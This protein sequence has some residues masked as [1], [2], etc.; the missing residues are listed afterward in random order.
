MS[1]SKVFLKHYLEDVSDVELLKFYRMNSYFR[2]LVSHVVDGRGGYNNLLAMVL[3]QK[4]AT[5]KLNPKSVLTKFSDVKLM[6]IAW[7]VLYSM[8][9]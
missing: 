6:Q 2:E 8:N 4:T 9:V 7:G 3:F 1:N 5:S